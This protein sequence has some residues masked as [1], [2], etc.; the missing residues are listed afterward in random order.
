MN[1]SSAFLFYAQQQ[2]SLRAQL[3]GTVLFARDTVEQHSAVLD[4]HTR[5]FAQAVGTP[6]QTMAAAKAQ[7]VYDAI[8][9]QQQALAAHQATLVQQFGVSI[10]NQLAHALQV[11]FNNGLATAETELRTD[12]PALDD[13]PAL[14]FEID[15]NG[16]VSFICHHSNAEDDLYD[17]QREAIDMALDSDYGWVWGDVVAVSSMD[18][19]FDHRIFEHLKIYGIFKDYKAERQLHVTWRC[20]EDPHKQTKLCEYVAHC[21]RF[22]NFLQLAL[23]CAHQH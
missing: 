13:D 23:H 22:T 8:F 2:T 4:M 5:A 18:I 15:T 14:Q 19:Q 21:A 7:G 17:W 6:S 1:T 20:P 9:A 10:S 3:H 12:A 11:T 16:R